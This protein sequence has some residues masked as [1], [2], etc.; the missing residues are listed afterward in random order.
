MEKKALIVVFV[1]FAMMFGA[2]GFNVNIGVDQGSGNV[3]TET[4]EVSDFDRLSLSG[5]GDVTLTQGNV[6]VDGRL[7]VIQRP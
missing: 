5:I 2:C 6:G 7:R 3:I 1:L 4:R